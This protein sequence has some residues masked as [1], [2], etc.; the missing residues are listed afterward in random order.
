MP[1][2]YPKYKTVLNRLLEASAAVVLGPALLRLKP[3]AAQKHVRA[4]LLVE[5]FGMGDVL[6]LSVMLDPLKQAFP[7]AD[8]LLLTKPGNENIYAH[9][10][11][12]RRTFTAPMPWS[13]LSGQKGG[14]WR[15]WRM[16]FRVCRE[17]AR[18]KPDIGLD[19]R[20]EVRSQ[21]LMVLC[22]CR[23]RIGFLNYLNT[24]IH[25]R[26]WLLSRAVPKPEVLPRYEMNRRLLSEGLDLEVPSL[27]FPSFKPDIA[28]ETLATDGRQ[29]LL[30]IGAR[31]AYRKWPLLRWIELGRRL[32]FAGIQAVV[33]GSEQ[34][35]VEAEKIGQS[36]G[37]PVVVADMHR[38]T[39][40]VKGSALVVCLDSG[41]MHLAQTLGVPVV[42]LFGP[43]DFELWRPLGPR[44]Q[45]VFHR[46][47]CNP[48]LQNGCV[49]PEDRCMVRISEDEV[50]E[51][52]M[53]VLA[54]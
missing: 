30:H 54:T 20:S 37:S 16:L 50:F 15:E 49:R 9:D 48:C 13:K 39:G 4:I 1:L 17:I 42:A 40:L 24:N 34:E 2:K 29:V 28:P 19:T 27:A 32:K 21:I 36:V 45:T 33:V 41:P 3:A 52:I 10:R 5:P 44:D 14:T 31:W 6:S 53:A 47:P 18:L 51:R 25:Q 35:Q 11:R 22:G 46:L 43:G 26:G 12:V 23:R 8:V 7:E 38:L